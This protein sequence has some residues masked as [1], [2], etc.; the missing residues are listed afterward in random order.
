MVAE[1]ASEI[2]KNMRKM[3][4]QLKVDADYLTKV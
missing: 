4:T 2:Y 1:Y 3:E